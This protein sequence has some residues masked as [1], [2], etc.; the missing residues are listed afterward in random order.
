MSVTYIDAIHQAMAELLE[1][2]PRV[3]LYGEDIAGSFGGAFKA[4]KGLAERFPERVLNAPIAEDAI[5]GTAIGAAIGGMK[6][7]VEMQ[8]ADFGILALNQM[9]NNA[10]AHYFRTGMPLNITLRM[11]CGGTPGGGPYHSQ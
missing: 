6:P 11:P 2:D 1:E 9:C 8:F 4:T 7:I 3:F 5:M 10:A